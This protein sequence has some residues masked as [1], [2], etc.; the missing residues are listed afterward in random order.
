MLGKSAKDVIEHFRAWCLAE[1]ALAGL[2]MLDGLY[3]DAIDRYE[4]TVKEHCRVQALLREGL[5]DTLQRKLVRRE[6]KGAI[7]GRGAIRPARVARPTPPC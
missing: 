2:C 1:N 4:N 5:G 6:G 7:K 3:A